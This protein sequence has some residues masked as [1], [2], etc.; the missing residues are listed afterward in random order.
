MKPKLREL[1]DEIKSE[2]ELFGSL[3]V[4]RERWYV[5]TY[6]ADPE[7]VSPYFESERDAVDWKDNHCS[8]FKCDLGVRVQ[9]LRAFTELRWTNY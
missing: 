8:Q 4:I 3:P 1:V 7:V 5:I 6:A 2:K 9:Y